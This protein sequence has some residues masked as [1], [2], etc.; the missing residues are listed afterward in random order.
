MKNSHVR[1]MIRSYKRDLPVRWPR[2]TSPWDHFFSDTRPFFRSNIDDHFRDM[3]KIMD[4]MVGRFTPY[5]R[6]PRTV[7][8]ITRTESAEVKYDTKVFEVK[9]DVQQYEPEHLKVSL[10]DNRLVISGKHET[11]ADEH[12]FISREFSR[13]FLIPE[14]VDAETI[15]SRLTD[16]GYL[17][18]EAKIKGA[19]EAQE[20]VIEIQKDGGKTE[21]S[22]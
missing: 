7:G 8:P 3:T 5:G 18:I 21:K 14:N 12:G 20:R 11:K 9:V 2:V 15:S 16:D 10:V 1:P 19:T 13:E 17:V 6:Y 4:E 22:D